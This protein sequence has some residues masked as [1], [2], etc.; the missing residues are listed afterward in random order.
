[1]RSAECVA[2]RV[3]LFSAGNVLMKQ[4]LRRLVVHKILR[5]DQTVES[6]FLAPMGVIYKELTVD[7]AKILEALE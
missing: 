3:L 2:V 7:M 5:S 4:S 6:T 1:M